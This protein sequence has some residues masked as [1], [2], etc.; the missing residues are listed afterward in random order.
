MRTAS[1]VGGAREDR[2]VAGL[3]DAELPGL[4]LQQEAGHG[5]SVAEPQVVGHQHLVQGHEPVPGEEHEDGPAVGGEGVGGLAAGAVVAAEVQLAGG[6]GF[7][8][9]LA[10]AGGSAWVP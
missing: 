10:G 3:V 6:G 7:G 4:G 5:A 8:A 9:L 2:D 1:G